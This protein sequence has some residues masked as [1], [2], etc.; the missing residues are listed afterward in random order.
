MVVIIIGRTLKTLLLEKCQVVE[1]LRSRCTVDRFGVHRYL[2]LDCNFDMRRT[3]K[4]SIRQLSLQYM[5]IWCKVGKEL[6]LRE[7]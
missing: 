4:C 6:G 1:D 5:K 2:V 7:R 3:C